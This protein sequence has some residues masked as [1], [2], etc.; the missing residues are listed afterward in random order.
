MEAAHPTT[1]LAGKP[2]D[3]AQHGPHRPPALADERQGYV[4]CQS[5]GARFV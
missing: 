1:I 4:D 2:A 3:L 5:A